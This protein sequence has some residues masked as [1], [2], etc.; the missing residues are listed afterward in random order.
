MVFKDHFRPKCDAERHFGLTV[1]FETNR[2]SSTNCLKLDRKWW[3]IQIIPQGDTPTFS[4][5]GKLSLLFLRAIFYFIFL[6]I[7]IEISAMS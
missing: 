3:A 1:T 2:R 6:R 4:F 5:K 7:Q